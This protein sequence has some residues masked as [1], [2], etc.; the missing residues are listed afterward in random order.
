V[1]RNAIA[2]WISKFFFALILWL[3]Y[4]QSPSSQNPFSSKDISPVCPIIDLSINSFRNSLLLKSSFSS[5]L[6]FCCLKSVFFSLYA[7]GTVVLNCINSLTS[8]IYSWLTNWMYCLKL[9]NVMY[10][11]LILSSTAS[12]ILSFLGLVCVLRL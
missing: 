8:P 9:R 5:F 2:F 7:R 12:L 4:K 10:P 6:S 11:M 1:A 3:N